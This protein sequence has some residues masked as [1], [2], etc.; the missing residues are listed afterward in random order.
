M[1]IGN[2]AVRAVGVVVLLGGICCFN[3]AA[4]ADDNGSAFGGV[5]D[6]NQNQVVALSQSEANNAGV[7]QAARPLLHACPASHPCPKTQ[8]MQQMQ[9]MQQTPQMQQQ[10]T[11]Q[12]DAG[13]AS[14]GQPVQNFKNEVASLSAQ[15][16][17]S[18]SGGV[19]ANSAQAPVV[20]NGAPMAVA[21]A[22]ASGGA[23]V[24]AANYPNPANAYGNNA[25]GVAPAQPAAATA[26]ASYPSLLQL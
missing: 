10:V 20:G 2:V 16:A 8:Q 17:N 13:S 26:A 22:P 7:Q 11:G 25:S 19:A 24:Y 5:S 15:A 14:Q 12:Q 21:A 23:Q 6:S 18:G 9:Q 3:E 1:R 4:L